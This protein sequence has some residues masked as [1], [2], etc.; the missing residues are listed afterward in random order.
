MIV[1]FL[2]ILG[3]FLAVM[4]PTVVFAQDD[5]DDEGGG[6]IRIE[7]LSKTH[8]FRLSGG[9]VQRLKPHGNDLMG[10]RI[11]NSTGGI[12]FEH[13]DVVIP[14]NS[15]LEVALRRKI[16]QGVTSETPF[17]HAFGDW[18]LDLPIAYIRHGG[19]PAQFN[20]GCLTNAG[21]IGAT[22]SFSAPSGAS[23]QVDSDKSSDGVILHVPGKG[24]SGFQGHHTKPYD[25]KAN[26]APGGQST[27]FAG[28]CATVVIGPDG[29]KYKF[30]RSATRRAKGLAVPYE[31]ASYNGQWVKGTHSFYRYYSVYLVT[32]VLDVHGNWVRYDYNSRSELTRIYSNDARSIN[33]TYKVTS[34]NPTY[35][36][37][38]MV[39]SVTANGRTWIYQY[40]PHS[41]P[42][43]GMLHKVFLPDGRHWRLGTST[44]GLRSM[45]YEPHEFT[46]CAPHDTTMTMKHPDGATGTFRLRE[47]NFLAS[48]YRY[49]GTSSNINVNIQG[50]SHSG[51]QIMGPAVTYPNNNQ[52]NQASEPNQ[53]DEGLPY[54]RAMSVVSK[55]IS[56]AGLPTATWDFE[57]RLQEPDAAGPMDNNWT[58]V[59]G[60]DGT[61]RK[62]HYLA[63]G[64]GHGLLKKEEVVPASGAGETITY[65]HDLTRDVS[66]LL[67]PAIPYDETCQTSPANDDWYN[68]PFRP[69]AVYDKRPVKKKTIVRDGVTYTSEYTFNKVNTSRFADYGQPNRIK[70]YSSQQST[71]R[72]TDVTYWHRASDNIVGLPLRIVKNGKEFDRVGY[73]TK[74]L[75]TYHNRFGVRWETYTY[76]ADGNLHTIKDPRNYTATLTNYY[77]G[78]P[79]TFTRRDGKILYRTL[80]A[81]GWVTSET[82][83]KGNVTGYEY[84]DVGWMTKV[85]RPSP[86]ADTNITYSNVGTSTFRQYAVRGTEEIITFYDEYHRPWRE[87]R[88]A[89]SGGGLV[90][91][92]KKTFDELGRETFSSFPTTIPNRQPTDGI[93]TTYDGLGRVLTVKENVA[94]FATTSYEYLAGNK[95]RVT[96]PEGNQ[97]TTTTTAFGSPSD[98]EPTRI[99]Q[100]LG[101]FT[102]MT[103]DIYGNLLTATQYGD[104]NGFNVTSTQ[105]HYYDSRLRLCR[106]SVPETG[107]TLYQYDN[108]NQV[109]GLAKGQAVGTACTAP[110][111]A[112]KIASTY[113]NLGRVTLVN[114]PGSTPDI[115]NEYDDNGNV[116]RRLRGTSDWRYTYDN[117]N[118]LTEEKLLIDGRTYATG[119]EY[120]TINALAFQTFSTGRRVEFAPNG[121]G[122]ATKAKHV[123]STTYAS[124]ITYHTNGNVNNINYGNGFV[125]TAA[126]NSRQLLSSIYTRK[127]TTKAVH[128]G[129]AHDKNG[130][131]TA[132]NDSAVSGQNKAFTYD[133]LN[134]LKTASGAWG[135]GNFTYDALDNI[136]R[137]QLGSRT[138][139]IQYFS[140]NNRLQRVRDT[141]DGNAWKNYAYDTRGNVTNNGT[142]GFT[143]DFADQPTATSGG[144]ASGSY[145]YDG[146][147]KRAKQ[148]VAGKTIYSIYGASGSLIHRDDATSNVKTDYVQAAGK[149]I[150]RIKGSSVS[151]MHQ[152]HLGSPVSS[153]TSAG[154]I[155]WREDFTPYGEKRLDP[156]ANQDDEG[157]TGHIDDSATGLTYMQARY[158]DPVIGRFL[159]K[160]PIGFRRGG[161]RYFNRYAYVGNEPV[162]A[163]DPT[164]EKIEYAADSPQNQAKGEAA[165]AYLSGS[166]THRANME[167]MEASP[168]TYTIFSTTQMDSEFK[169]DSRTVIMNVESTLETS[170]GTQSPALGGAHEISHAERHTRDP[171]GLKTDSIRP[172]GP[173]VAPT[174]DA[175]GVT[176]ITVSVG[177]A[178]EEAR[179][180]SVE[181]QIAKELGEPQRSDYHDT[182]G[183]GCST[184]PVPP[185]NSC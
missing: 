40:T 61:K 123:G 165:L 4:V 2:A 51:Y 117:A 43:I 179:A 167:A 155:A 80:D 152:D 118:Q 108:A 38:K 21:G 163:F 169:P 55:T 103:Y 125:H 15:G 122:Q 173:P 66:S 46:K 140:S 84:N 88:R 94:P 104:Q 99:A 136:R 129:Y 24:L 171:G 96:D 10:D 76:H 109:T 54:Y 159:S 156:T 27:D 166:A 100:P 116:T 98:G 119:Y 102:D 35:L 63:F 22:L 71:Q 170:N 164:G 79:R 148:V 70:K 110:P 65:E 59:T 23:A 77:R 160:D 47:T 138:V 131:I 1:R 87:R 62:Y 120:N 45:I 143:Y 58:R 83:A 73:N 78:Q 53:P 111:A 52:C 174:V 115:S 85:D 68:G 69:C 184:S 93:E 161:V 34:S 64:E 124:G 30:G 126:Y 113:D 182:Q 144:A 12:S 178:P 37:S 177:I 181:N 175:N 60:P 39:T 8:D 130:R 17:Q 139:E 157:F 146:N 13:T 107:D 137:K 19:S 145:V 150:A 7:S 20:G 57:Y 72:I 101:K 176:I 29:T 56:G 132:I 162:N 91:F 81:N 90:T 142:F 18:V 3:I 36:N 121:M 28:R 154:T 153:T 25:P 141:G 44:H 105:K 32:E 74:G 133:G 168:D 106:H 50:N 5:D 16:A 11:D 151:Y 134:R 128:F 42:N 95:V 33:L 48:A 112:S 6:G 31:Y 158:Y 97:T 172:P 49:T 89:I 9:M 41:D 92:T 82:D 14:G 147:L 67:Y 180:T 135:S 149:T 114:F 86:W 185:L 26:W 75:R 183:T 127:G